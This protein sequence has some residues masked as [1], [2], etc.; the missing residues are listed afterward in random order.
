[1]MT[2]MLIKKTRIRPRQMTL[3]L[4]KAGSYG[5]LRGEEKQ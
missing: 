4:M 5:K 1:M 2:M 3:D